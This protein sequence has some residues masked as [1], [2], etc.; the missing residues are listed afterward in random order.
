MHEFHLLLSEMFCVRL[1]QRLQRVMRKMRRPEL[2]GPE[3]A[4]LFQNGNIAKCVYIKKHNLSKTTQITN[5]NLI[6]FVYAFSAW[7]IV[8]YYY[9]YVLL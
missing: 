6:I 1:S 8:F 5:R 3:F 2:R 7:T 4:I 9:Y